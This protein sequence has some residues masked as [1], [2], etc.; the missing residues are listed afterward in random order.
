MTTKL[1]AFACAALLLAGC[2]S[3]NTDSTKLTC[4]TAQQA[5]TAYQALLASGAVDV[6]PQTVAYVK[7]AASFLGMYCGWTPA[8]TGIASA[9]GDPPPVFDANG[10]PILKKP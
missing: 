10:V 4:E 8:T 5:Y 7:V 3:T 9:K 1:F 6:D 2:S